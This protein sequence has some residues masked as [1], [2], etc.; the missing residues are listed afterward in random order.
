MTP[1]TGDIIGG[2]N[3]AVVVAAAIGAVLAGFLLPPPQLDQ[4]S[5]VWLSLGRFVVAV[6]VL[7][8]TL[9]ITAWFTRRHCIPLGG[10]HAGGPRAR[11][12]YP[13]PVPAGC[14]PHHSEV[15]GRAR[16][17]QYRLPTASGFVAPR[18]C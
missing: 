3:K 11:D 10:H 6:L 1:R 16:G 9:P 18:R 7:F 8:L 17:P 2:W 13:A 12:A 5:N 15:R 4:E 14:R